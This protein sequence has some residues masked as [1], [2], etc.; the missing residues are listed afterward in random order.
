MGIKLQ[1]ADS[2]NNFV[3]VNSRNQ[4]QVATPKDSYGGLSAGFVQMSSE[5]DAGTVLGVRSVLP[6][7]ASDDYRLRVGVDQTLFNATF[8]GAS[9]L[10]TQWSNSSTNFI[11]SMAQSGFVTINSSSLNT[12]AAATN[13]RTWRHF[14]TFG[15]YPT[16][17]EMWIREGGYDALNALSEWGYLYI[18]AQA[19]RQVPDG[20]YFRRTSGGSLK[21]IITNNSSDIFEID[22]DTRTVP[23]RDGYG[24]YDP[25]ET[26]HY[27][28]SFH[29]DIARFWIND[30][31][32]GE[33]PCPSQF[34]TVTG[35]SN[36]PIAFRIANFGT[37]SQPR[38]LNIGYVNVGYGDQNVNKPWSH[39]MSG[40]G[41]G[42][43]QVQIGNTPGPTVTRTSAQTGHPASGTARSTTAWSATTNP[44]TV[45]LGGLWN[46]TVLGS[47]SSDFD[48]PLFTYLNPV[49]GPN[50]SAKTLYITSVRIGESSI[51]A[52]PGSTGAFFSYIVQVENSAV[53]TSTADAATTTSGKA[54]VIGGQGFAPSEP[55]GTMKPGFEMTFNPPLVVS[56]NK[57]FTVIARPFGGLFTGG[58]LT[59]TGS[60][61]VNGYWE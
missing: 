12:D 50:V 24:V 6:L 53:A 23:S 22:I 8:E 61:G 43:Y 30:V 2:A 37:S 29:N 1:G 38:V 10:T 13:F 46:S 17:C 59:V 5:I 21:G 55:L 42:A 18:F 45:N 56:P 47:I 36:L 40:M 34:A 35:S 20:V 27:L 26:N 19:T 60:V 14:P 44:G 9:V 51:T 57:Y 52:A 15:T 28:I 54:T 31:V 49:A 39:A 58:L 33:I 4:L 16:Y 48:Y 25:A 11:V 32:V 41:G 7:E 3:N